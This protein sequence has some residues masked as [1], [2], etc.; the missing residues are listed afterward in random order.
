MKKLLSYILFFT[1]HCSFAQRVEVLEY[2]PAPG[3]FV[4]TMPSADETTGYDEVCRRCEERLNDE[5]LVHLGAF[6]GYITVRFDHP[7]QNL[8]GSDFRIK[9]NSAYAISDPVYGKNTIGGSFEPGIVYVGVGN[10][11]ATAEWYELAGSEYY[12]S[13]IHDF[14]V[15]YY[16]PTAESGSHEKVASVYDD[17]IRWEASWTENGVRRD[18]TGYHNKNQ[19]HDQ[20]YWPL[21]EKAES[22]TFRGGRLPNNGV[23]YSGKGTSWVLYRY[24]KDAYGYVDASLNSDDYS[25]FDIDWAV[26]KQGNR[27]QLPQIDFIR[28]QSAVFQ[29]CGWIGETSTEVGEFTDLHLQPGYDENPIVITPQDPLRLPHEGAEGKTPPHERIDWQSGVYDVYGRKVLTPSRGIY[30][31][32]RKKVVV[33]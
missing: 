31:R 12:T 10:D 21:W 18:S 9:G 2:H 28:V 25:T 22:L 4:N 20:T 16:K 24:A 15:T 14:T 6:G 30:I 1:F 11:P 27:V 8:R 7:V 29:H 3:Q 26:D 5:A 23:D 17:Y 33:N 32:N 13:E 19:F